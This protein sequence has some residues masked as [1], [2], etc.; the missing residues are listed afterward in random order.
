MEPSRN[1]RKENN[2]EILLS[3]M[4]GQLVCTKIGFHVYMSN[5]HLPVSL[6]KVPNITK[7]GSQAMRGVLRES[8]KVDEVLAILIVFNWIGFDIIINQNRITLQLIF[9]F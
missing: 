7:N 9:M 2:W 6:K 3:T 5:V 4:F 8:K 1:F